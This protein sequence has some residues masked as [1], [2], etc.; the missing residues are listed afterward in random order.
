MRSTILRGA[1]AALVLAAAGAQAAEVNVYSA[2][3]EELIKPLLDRFTAQ[4]GITVNLVTGKA[5]ALLTRLQSEGQNS[6]ADLLLTVDAGNLHRAREAGVVQAVK[7]AALERDIPPAYRDPDGYWF[8][9]SLRARTVVYAKD[10]VKPG[11]IATYEDLAAPKWKGRICVRSSD[12]IYNQSHV[13]GMIAALGEA[14]TEAW[15]RGLVAN[16]ARPPKG[17]DRDQVKAVAA[18]ECDVA[19][20]N[21]YYLGGMITGGDADEKSAAGKVAIAWPNQKDRGVHV[22]VSGAA[23]TRAAK[24]REAAVRLIEFLASDASQA[25]YAD[26]NME[27]PVR[28]GIPVNAT[29]K[30]WG[31]FKAESINLAALGTY[32]AAAVRLM[33]RAGWK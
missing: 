14:K 28:D 11:E 2:R 3:K 13:A 10:R 7:S 4:T 5:D 19:L 18:G 25:W 17:G 1:V 31:N 29:L 30:A 23:V 8:G 22:N 9:L 15:A 12:N 6:P 24:N 26:A 16:F 32:N 21:T 20:V 33:D 27:F